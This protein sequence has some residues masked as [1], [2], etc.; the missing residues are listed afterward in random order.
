MRLL[1]IVSVLSVCLGLSPVTEK[2][3]LGDAPALIPK[4]GP[5]EIAE[6]GTIVEEVVNV[7]KRAVIVV[8]SSATERGRYQRQVVRDTWMQPLNRSSEFA[9]SSEQRRSFAVWFV[10]PY[11]PTGLSVEEEGK[12]HGDIL[13]IKASD[14]T[15]QPSE[16]EVLGSVLRWA[17]VAYFGHY[18]FVAV[19]QDTAFVSLMNLEHFCIEN[20]QRKFLYTGSVNSYEKAPDYMENRYYTPFVQ[21]GTMVVSQEVVELLARELASIRQLPRVDATIGAFLMTYEGGKAV[22][23][24]RFV[25]SPKNTYEA[26]ESPII[27]N[28]MSLYDMMTLSK[29]ALVN[30]H[31][32]TPAVPAKVEELT[33]RQIM[34]NPHPTDAEPA[35]DEM[36]SSKCSLERLRAIDESGRHHM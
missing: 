23:D 22:H 5:P 10:V 20:E 1:L 8:F 30:G 2:L 9:L 21:F 28:E 3:D 7:H 27:V 35:C 16:F 36:A 14:N 17:R 19:T 11:N 33:T 15:T 24:K 25:A 32:E 29:P 13:L 18:D 26:V 31:Y 34:I 12:L 6:D 4:P